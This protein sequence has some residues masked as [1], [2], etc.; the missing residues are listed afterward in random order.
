[1]NRNHA[2]PG[3][4]LAHSNQAQISPIRFAVG[5]T[6]APT[7]AVQAD[8]L[9]RQMPVA[10]IRLRVGLGRTNWIPGGRQPLSRPPHRGWRFAEPLGEVESPAV[11]L[12]V[13]SLLRAQATMKPAS[14]IPFLNGKI[15]GGRTGQR[16]TT[17]CAGVPM[18][19]LLSTT[20]AGV[21]ELL[22]HPTSHGHA[23]WARFFLQ[24]GE[25]FVGKANCSCVTQPAV[26]NPYQRPAWLPVVPLALVRLTLSRSAVRHPLIQ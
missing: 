3:I 23:G 19:S 10:A 15:P 9:T 7:P 21:L 25:K 14:D 16:S 13:R 2:M 5:V 1:V 24:P 8:S 26:C 4:D 20:G 12:I 17:D 22:A 11:M 6:P 18:E